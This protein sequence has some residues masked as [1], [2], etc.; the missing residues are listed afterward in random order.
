MGRPDGIEVASALGVVVM[1]IMIVTFYLAEVFSQRSL[2][3]RRLSCVLLLIGVLGVSPSAAAEDDEVV[4]VTP[5]WEGIRHEF[6]TAFSE[7]WKRETGRAVTFRWLDVG[8]TSDIV[9]YIK[10]QFL[11]SSQG[12]GIDLFFGGGVDSFMELER[13]GSLASANVSER[14][15]SAIPETLA[16]S[17]IYSAKRLWFSN[18]FSAFGLLYNKSAISRLNLPTPHSW[19]DLAK[20]EYFDLVGA[21]DPRKSGSM[22][23]MFEIILQGYGWDRGWEIIQQISRNVRNYSGGASVIGKEVATGEV[24]YG[25]AIDTYAGDIIR[26]VGADRLG[27]ALPEDFAAI[28]GDGIALLKGAPHASVATRFIE[29]L[30]SDAGQRLWYGKKGSIGGPKR[31][32]LGK[33]SVLPSVYGTI[34]PATLFHG[35]P[36]TL[37]NIL[38]YDAAKAARRWNLVNDLFGAFIIDVHERL[39]RTPDPQVLKGIPVSEPQAETLSA[40]GAWGH[41][42]SVR[43]DRIRAWG[44]EARKSLPLP[45]TPS[46]QFKWVP[47]FL[48]G[49][50]LVIALFRQFF[51]RRATF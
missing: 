41:D 20:P 22:H 32:E 48:L 26:Q 34:E 39:V 16:G 44:D 2:R 31:Y 43:T 19:A 33:L 46:E 51:S 9:K 14:V 3:A 7:Q 15:L 35:N 37:A 17:P 42:T 28:N 10:N 49:A 21:G 23:A 1:L 8:G 50:L 40:G 38:P 13:A 29:F 30:L 36:F 27:F 5:H 47:S 12:I 18:A 4:I 6:S 11:T 24:V 25:I 45:L